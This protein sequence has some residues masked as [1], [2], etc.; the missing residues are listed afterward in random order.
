M[1]F[2]K[3][4]PDHT[5]HELGIKCQNYLKAILKSRLWN[6]ITYNLFCQKL[7]KKR[8]RDIVIYRIFDYREVYYIYPTAI[9]FHIDFI[10]AIYYTVHPALLLINDAALLLLVELSAEAWN[11]VVEL[12]VVDVC[13][14]IGGS[15]FSLST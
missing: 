14:E 6:S 10:I 7:K 8:M 2:E 5:N 4:L 1:V 12:V 9:T 11:G 13:P 15:P 3:T